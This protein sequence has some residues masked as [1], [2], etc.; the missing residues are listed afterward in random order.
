[1]VACVF[2]QIVTA[3]GLKGARFGHHPRLHDL[4]HTWAARALESCPSEKGL[5]DRH[6]RAVMTYLGHANVASSYWYMHNTPSLMNRIADAF[7]AQEQEVR[8]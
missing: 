5:I 3:Q 1:M 6:A 4:R 2:H 7:A 8:S